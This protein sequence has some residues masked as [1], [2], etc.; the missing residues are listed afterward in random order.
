MIRAIL[1]REGGRYT[2]YRASGHSGYA[3]AGA[4]IVC[5]A[6]SSLSCTC[7]NALESLLGIRA[8]VRENREGLMAFDLP[9]GAIDSEGAQL[10]LGALKQ[11][12]S[13]LQEG[14][15]ENIHLSIKE[16]RQQS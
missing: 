11:G 8:E 3:E 16:R 12:L 13:D 6:V 15:P 2:G 9:D 4:D 10:L 7:V 14:Y 5:A 1:Y